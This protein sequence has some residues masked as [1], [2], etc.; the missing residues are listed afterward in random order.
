M[1][2]EPPTFSRHWRIDRATL[3][4]IALLAAALLWRVVFFFEMY[5]SPYADNLT[6]DS[7]VYH[8]VALAV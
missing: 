2:S 3:I 1:D 8:E 5:A 4:V 7:Q 6:L